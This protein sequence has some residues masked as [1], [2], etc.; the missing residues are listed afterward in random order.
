M[1]AM[2]NRSIEPIP[3]GLRRLSEGLRRGCLGSS[4]AKVLMSCSEDS[5]YFSPG[6]FCSAMVWLSLR[7]VRPVGSC[8]WEGAGGRAVGV[9]GCG[10]VL[11]SWDI[12]GGGSSTGWD[13]LVLPPV[14]FK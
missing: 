9:F 2:R 1:L 5:R 8:G 10:P 14:A 4:S 13:G 11:V 3:K 6:L 12:G 7:T